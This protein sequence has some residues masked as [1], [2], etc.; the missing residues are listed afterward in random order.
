MSAPT[1]LALPELGRL[2]RA[3]ELSCV[4]LAEHFLDRLERMGSTYNA[5]V[6]VLR[7]PA[8]AEARLRDRELI[9]GQGPRPAARHS[10]RR[11]GSAGR[12]GRAHELGSA[13]VSEPDVARGC[14]GGPTASGRGCGAGGQAG[15]GRARRRHGVQPGVRELHRPRPLTLG[16]G[17]LVR[18]VLQRIGVGGRRRTG[19]L[20]D[21]LG[22]LGIDPVSR[23]RSAA[24]PA[25]A[26]P[27]GG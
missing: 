4:E 15:D 22:D 25:C 8:L 3:R 19:S 14:D 16:S 23:R 1:W 13:A 12:R 2:L 20:R 11:Q 24:S 27:M 26:R 6:T 7:E 10:L 18:R 21:R 17:P 5:V 9:S